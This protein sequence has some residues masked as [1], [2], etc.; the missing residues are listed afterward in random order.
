MLTKRV[1]VCEQ[2]LTIG[3]VQNRSETAATEYSIEEILLPDGYE[4]AHYTLR[5]VYDG[6]LQSYLSVNTSV[7]PVQTIPM[8]AQL[9]ETPAQ[10]LQGNSN[11]QSS[12][13]SLPIRS[14]NGNHTNAKKLSETTRK[15]HAHARDDDYTDVCGVIS[16]AK[17]NPVKRINPGKGEF[18]CPRCGSNFTRPKSVKDH[19]PDCV[20]KYGN[21]KG[22]RYTD[23]PSMVQ[24]EAAIKRRRQESRGTSGMGGEDEMSDTRCVQMQ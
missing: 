6:H 2:G 16:P 10:D 3:V 24:K 12:T 14:S 17:A 23:H 21:P 22:L 7:T 20:A 18:C 5:R 1:N 13:F 11:N 15:R 19:F 9:S 4:L 8:P